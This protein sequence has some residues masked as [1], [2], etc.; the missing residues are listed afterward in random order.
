MTL[1]GVFM[2]VF[3]M[4]EGIDE[5]FT[6]SRFG[7]AEGNSYKLS[8]VDLAYHGENLTWYKEQS[9]QVPMGIP[10]PR[11]EVG[12]GNGS[13]TDFIDFTKF[14]DKSTDTDFYRNLPDRFD[15]G[16]FLRQCAVETFLVNSD[17]YLWNGNNYYLYHD[18]VSKKWVKFT[19]D[20]EESLSKLSLRSV[21]AFLLHHVIAYPL[22][23]RVLNHAEY[24]KQLK[25]DFVKILIHTFGPTE[26][27]AVKPT[28]R[29][30]AYVDF[31]RP[32]MQRDDL[33]HLSTGHAPGTD[34]FYDDAK[35]TIE[36]LNIR[37]TETWQQLVPD[38]EFLEP[39]IP[40]DRKEWE[41]V[42]QWFN[43][44][45]ETGEWLATP[46]EWDNLL[47]ETNV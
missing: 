14:L 10:V 2:G 46:G 38:P 47:G 12:Q 27:S 33:W 34:I 1:N 41:R 37:A 8:K 16:N 35:V 32:L 4:H 18:P 25:L 20:Y 31:L 36:F 42:M 29:Y 13:W 22:V 45:G 3:W 9:F 39:L 40:G 6:Q 28:E 19:Y 24:M 43:K 44:L 26:Y 17:G 11:Y 15:L 5:H 30:A 21:T 7:S 23:R